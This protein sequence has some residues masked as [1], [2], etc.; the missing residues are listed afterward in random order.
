[1][2]FVHS[3]Y[4]KVSLR[5]YLQYETPESLIATIAVG[6][7]PSIPAQVVL[8]WSNGVLFTIAGFQPGDTLTKENIAGHL[9][10]DH[11][12]FTLMPKFA[13]EIHIS[14]KPLLTIN[15]ID[16]SKHPIFGPFA[17]WIKTNAA[18]KS[19]PL[20]GPAR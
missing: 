5:S 16:L 1:M 12:D 14:D 20:Q 8:R 6:A 7:T 15:I 19:P 3:P 11:V 9:L 4:S 10:W 18:A 17:E 2:E 13:S